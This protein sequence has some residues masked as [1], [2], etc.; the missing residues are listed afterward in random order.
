MKNFVVLDSVHGSFIVNRNCDF[1]AETLIKTG[2]THIESELSNILTIIDRLPDHAVVIDAGANV[3]FFSV[4]VANALIKKNGTVYAFEVQVMIYNAL[5]GTIALNDLSN[6]KAFNFGLSDMPGEVAVQFPDYSQ[7]ADYGAFSLLDQTNPASE[8]QNKVIVK[9]ID[10]LELDRLDFLKIDVEGM[11][12]SVLNGGIKAIESFRPWCWVEYW[13]ISRSLLTQFF[14]SRDYTL[15]RMDPL[16]VLCA[17]NEKLR[18]SNILA[19]AP[20]F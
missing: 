6:I 3:G 10:D 2:A 14:N 1:H 12:I 4:P 18:T 19:N 5:C 8:Y 15:Y 17:P 13:K 9:R 11:E 16:N 7:A 20:L